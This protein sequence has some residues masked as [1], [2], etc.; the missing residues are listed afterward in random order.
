MI[1]NP[2]NAAHFFRRTH[3]SLPLSHIYALLLCFYRVCVFFVGLLNANFVCIFLPCFE[4][5][6]VKISPVV[7]RR[8]AIPVFSI[9]FEDFFCS[10]FV[11]APAH[12]IRSNN[13]LQ[14]IFSLSHS[15]NKFIAT[16]L[17]CKIEVITLKSLLK[18]EKKKK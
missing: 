17:F 1:S 8:N 6:I 7:S 5:K 10:S 18:T 16:I 2:K 15:S 9:C 12:P 4:S 14:S 13:V 11:R 3:C